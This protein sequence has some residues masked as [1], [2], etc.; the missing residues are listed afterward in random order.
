[1]T[2]LDRLYH[3][4]QAPVLTEKGTDDQQKRNAYTFRVPI[5]ANKIEIKSAVEKL[6]K[7]KVLAVNTLRTMT[8]VKRRGY[9]SGTTPAW[10]KAMVMLKEGDTIE[11]L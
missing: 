2:S 5:D 10:K 8:K 6:F 4:I 9:V 3:I 7:V 11:L 1:M